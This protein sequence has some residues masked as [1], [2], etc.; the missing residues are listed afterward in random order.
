[1][2]VNRNRQS[3]RGNAGQPIRQICWLLPRELS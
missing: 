2:P 1:L 3:E